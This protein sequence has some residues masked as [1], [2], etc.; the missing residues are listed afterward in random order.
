M[1]GAIVGGVVAVAIIGAACGGGGRASTVTAVPAPTA[2]AAPATPAAPKATP[3]Q[4]A[5]NGALLTISDLPTGFTTTP[6]PPPDNSPGPCGLPSTHNSQV[7]HADAA[8]QRQ[9]S[10][11]SVT[12][13]GDGVASYPAGQ[14]Q[15]AM[16]RAQS[17]FNS[18]TTWT[19]T[20]N[21]E[22]CPPPLP[23]LA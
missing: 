18:C 13:V 17:T 2:T 11:V 6:S 19:S 22:T 9:T 10:I 4:A 21:G 3:D 20:T 14:A 12:S 8:F 15:A 1:R 7:A 23:S 5:L 16:N